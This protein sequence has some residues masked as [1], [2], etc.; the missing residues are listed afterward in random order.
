MMKWFIKKTTKRLF[1]VFL[2]FSLIGGTLPGLDFTLAAHA[3]GAAISGNWTDSGNYSAPDGAGAGTDAMTI[4]NAAELAW[5][6]SQVNTGNTFSGKT[7]RI[8][9]SVTEIDL[10]AHYWVPIGNSP[11]NS[12][13]GTFDGNGKAISRLTIGS[14]SSPNGSLRYA[15]LFG[16]AMNAALN[17][18]CLEN[19]AIYSSYAN[20]SSNFASIGGLAGYPCGTLNIAGCHVAGLLYSS[21]VYARIGGVIGRY[22][23]NDGSSDGILQAENCY[24]QCIIYVSPGNYSYA[25]GFAGQMSGTAGYPGTVKNCFATGSVYASGTYAYAGGFAGYLENVNVHNGFSNCNVSGSSGTHGGFVG[26]S[27]S[28]AC[29]NVYAAGANSVSAGTRGGLIGYN[30]GGSITNGYWNSSVCATANGV[31]SSM[32][33]TGA[34]AAKTQAEMQSSGF[35]T[36]LDANAGGIAGAVSWVQTSDK[37]AGYPRLSGI[38]DFSTAFPPSVMNARISG[39]TNYYV[40]DTLTL[41]YDYLDMNGYAGSGTA[42]QWYRSENPDGSSGEAIPGAT[43]TTYVLTSDD[44]LYCIYAGVTPSNG[45]KT[46]TEVMTARTDPVTVNETSTGDYFA[47]GDGSETS[48]YQ[49]ANRVQLKN[50]QLFPTA[51]YKLTADNITLDTILFKTAVAFSG[52]FNGNGKTIALAISSGSNQTCGMFG[53][54]SGNIRDLN[55][56]GSVTGAYYVGSLAGVNNG[57]IANC[58]SSAI[59][60]ATNSST[61]YACAGGLAGVNKGT[62]ADCG[63]TGTLIASSLAGDGSPDSNASFGGIAGDNFG[64]TITG[65][66]TD[67]ASFAPAVT[68]FDRVYAGGLA[69]YNNNGSIKES[70][71]VKGFTCSLV[72]PNASSAVYAGGLAGYMPNGSISQCFATGAITGSGECSVYAGGLVGY[73]GA[74]TVSYCYSAGS[75]AGDGGDGAGGVYTGGFVGYNVSGTTQH[76]YTRVSGSATGGSA[77]YLGG[78]YGGS[79][80]RADSTISCYWNSDNSSAAYGNGKYT[81]WPTGLPQ[82]T[83]KMTGNTHAPFYMLSLDNDKNEYILFKENNGNQWYFPQLKV[84]ADNPETAAASLASVTEVINSAELSSD[85][86][87]FDLFDPEDISLTITWNDAT[88]VNDIKT[89]VDYLHCQDGTTIGSGSYRLDTGD[90]DPG[91]DTLTIKKEYLATQPTG[92]LELTIE[93]DQGSPAVLAIDITDTTPPTISPDTVTYDLS[94]PGDVETVITW[95]SARSVADVVYNS[96]PL[97][98][99]TDYAIS[100]DILIIYDAYLSVQGFSDGDSPQFTITFDNDN[101]DTAIFTINIA[102]NYA[103]GRDASLQDLTVGGGT[104]S[105]F[106]A[107]TYL[108][109]TELPYGTLP[110]S[111]RARVG[112]TARD[113]KASVSIAQ[114]AELPGS[115]TVTVTAEDK[116]TLTYTVLFTLGAKSNNPPTEKYIVP[117]QNVTVGGTVRFSASDIADDEDDDTLAITG[118]V[119]EPASGIAA[120]SLDS[121]TVTITGEAA[122]STSVTVTVSDGKAA[123]DITV[124]I[125]VGSPGA[126]T[127]ALT[128]RAGTGGTI[129]AGSSGNY[130]S[131]AVISIAATAEGSYSFSGWA[132]TA[133]GTFGNA[134]SPATTFIMP[135]NATTVTANFRRIDKDDDDKHD[136]PARTYT[137]D[138]KG[139]D[140]AGGDIL[141]TT[142]PVTVDTDTGSA[143]VTIDSRQGNIVTN[144]GTAVVTVPSIPGIGAC[145]LEVP[146]ACLSE[147]DGK[148]TL[149]LSTDTGSMALPA[150]MLTGVPGLSGSTAAIT[151]GQGDRESLPDNIRGAIGDKPLIQLTLSIN[152][153]QTDWSNPNAP[154]TVSLPYSPTAGELLNPESIV[155]WYIDGSGKVVAIP[156]GHHDPATGTVTVDI[157][158]FS[159]YAVAYNPVRFSDVAADAWYSK[160]VGFIAARGITDGMGDGTYRPDARLTRGEFIVLVMRAYA[161]APDERPTDNFSDAGDACYTGY[162]AAAKRLGISAGTGNNMFAPGREITRQET[163]TLLYNALKAIGQLPEGNSGKT[164]DSFTDAGLIDSWAMDAV[165]LFAETGTI[166]G[167]AGKLDP[168]GTTTRAEMAQVLY[169]LLGK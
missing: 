4:D 63:M 130:A 56:T 103:P 43:G 90:G 21:G 16:Y 70:Y 61:H 168:T 68:S 125:L 156:N 91:A 11:T 155:I 32:N 153:R 126:Q 165:R 80:G 27:S 75:L 29:S 18:V 87:G 162:L 6:A 40:G 94:A 107:D 102:D 124:P 54:N 143:S 50:M 158:H 3:E 10:S 157:T 79:S 129:T 112:A 150:D 95:N 1:A 122:G 100:G 49:I 98:A 19:V 66:H 93:F 77:D 55:V 138:V 2:V 69:G 160:A 133:G 127:Y 15:G 24:S 142:L 76:S 169:N 30:Y 121:E 113:P 163:F 104:V 73:F 12:F 101:C 59:V 74:G 117:A 47:G 115:A 161:I 14:P 159:D 144:G 71:A 154:V 108:Y 106:A 141:K 136:A 17:N 139:T 96:N 62:I 97:T 72:T 135:A 81:D 45:V 134:G 42:V 33:S 137:A 64:G 58:I 36:D 148:G 119:A 111:A 28:S 23:C 53:S 7:I 67:M 46:G 149:I 140:S 82:T 105:G 78:A 99:E 116:T 120:A 41:T 57:T 83:F 35:L 51:Y 110:G 164:L 167:N 85:T 88:K 38:G 147:P 37:N 146:T 20:S 131:G 84:F 22:Y 34:P 25:G 31:G 118:I 48:P 86:A 166:G 39:S 44:Y 52:D 60:T 65:C 152:G 128:V 9:D 89:G 92:S 114:A 26:Y 109:E 8:A 145:T 123:A 132:S 13:Q 151:I 5:V